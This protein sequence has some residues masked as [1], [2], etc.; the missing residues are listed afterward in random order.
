M[1]WTL[2]ACSIG[3]VAAFCACASRGAPS[4]TPTPRTSASVAHF[5]TASGEP[6]PAYEAAWPILSGFY[7]ADIPP[8]ITVLIR[9]EGESVFDADRG[10]VITVSRR[11]L[12]APE[13]R[14]DAFGR[15]PPSELS[16]VTHETAHLAN[17]LLTRKASTLEALRFLDEGLATVMEKRADGVAEAYK[18]Y[19]LA[20]SA[21]RLSTGSV[22]LAAL[23]DWSAYFGVPPAADFSAYDVGAAFV[24][25][26]E[27]GYGDAKLRLL[28]ADLGRTQSLAASSQAIL[29]RDISQTEAAW[30]SYLR[31]VD[32]QVP[33]IVEMVPRNGQQDVG[34][35]T[36]EVRVTFD[37]DME[38]RVCVR[39]DC[40]DGVCYRDAAWRDGRVFVVKV[41]PALEPNH[42]Y[43]LSLGVPGPRG[44]R[45]MTKRGIEAPILTWT[46]RTR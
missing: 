1:R 20:F 22:R 38:P 17:A 24:F 40:D 4:S 26:I 10:D 28:L 35:D 15:G 29:G 6:L 27:D 33:S 7:G 11:S 19:A 18:A 37:T 21:G 2:R 31:R 8:K 5:Y 43:S 44:C 32:V 3:I 36:T 16:D 13:R 34:T 30:E 39:T 12:R 42:A 25:F 23:Q 9:S 45:M 46:F 41:K 14:L